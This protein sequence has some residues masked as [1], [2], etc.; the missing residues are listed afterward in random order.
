M[1]KHRLKLIAALA[2]AVLILAGNSSFA[3][4]ASYKLQPS[5]ILN[6]TVHGHPDLTT[7]VRLTIDGNISFPLVGNVKA[8]GLTVQELESALRTLLEAK[9]LVSAPVL[10]FIEEYHPRQVSIVG[11]VSKPG[12]YEMP[13]EKDMTLLEA[14]AMAGGFTKDALVEKVKIM[15]TENNKEKVITVNTKD[16][17]IRGKKDKDITLKPNDVIV[18]PESFF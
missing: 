4:T 8:E 9:Y 18:V 14:I 2:S 17:T 16:I 11:E 5:D 1:R 13:E 12:K 10:I 15:R 7:K 3:A 6:I